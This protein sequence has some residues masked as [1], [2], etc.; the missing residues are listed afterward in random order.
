MQLTK[1][2]R[3]N[4]IAKIVQFCEGQVKLLNLEPTNEVEFQTNTKTLHML[5]E[6]RR[7]NVKVVEATKKEL[8][9]PYKEV[10]EYEKAINTAFQTSEDIIM[11]A[12]EVYFRK[13]P[14]TTLNGL[15]PYAKESVTVIDQSQVPAQFL[16]TSVNTAAVLEYYKLTGEMPAGVSIE[17]IACL[18]RAGK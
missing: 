9:K 16:T 11:E 4:E 1:E 3:D 8:Y 10:Q 12:L 7:N 17:T 2:Q 5:A 6:N 14:E 13:H 15:T 18:K